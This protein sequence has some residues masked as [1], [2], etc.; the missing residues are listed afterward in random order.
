MLYGWLAVP[1][2]FQDTLHRGT[3][4]KDSGIPR[5]A[6]HLVV[7]RAS[8]EWHTSSGN[9]FFIPALNRREADPTTPSLIA[10]LSPWQR[11]ALFIPLPGDPYWTKETVGLLKAR[12]PEIDASIYDTEGGAKL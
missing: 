7:R 12:Y 3:P 1:W 2:W 10:R 5:I 11:S 8:A 9:G 6:H 4:V